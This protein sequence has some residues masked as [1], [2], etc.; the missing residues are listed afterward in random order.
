MDV[1]NNQV[2]QRY[3]FKYYGRNHGNWI[4]YGTGEYM[5]FEAIIYAT[6]DLKPHNGKHGYDIKLIASVIW[7]IPPMTH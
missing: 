7:E 4:L 3:R 1:I 6:A 2:M 5:F